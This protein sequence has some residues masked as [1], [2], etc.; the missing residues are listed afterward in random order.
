MFG[1]NVSG[2]ARFRV[3]RDRY[4]AFVDADYFTLSVGEAKRLIRWLTQA[5]A[6]LEQEKNK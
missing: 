5:V 3:S 2:F 1:S 6:W 4:G